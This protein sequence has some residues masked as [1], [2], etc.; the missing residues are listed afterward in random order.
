VFGY[1]LDYCNTLLYGM[2]QNTPIACKEY[3]TLSP[4]LYVMHHIVVHPSH[5]SNPCIGYQSSNVLSTNSPKRSTKFDYTSN[6]LT[7]SSTLVSINQ[8]VLRVHQIQSY[9]LFH[10]PKL[11]PQ[12]GLSASPS[13]L[14][15]I[16]CHPESEKHHHVFNCCAD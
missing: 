12:L 2:A 9:S 1:R 15:G 10:L 3:R 5:Y 8:F 4:D 16:V 11:Q 14:S 7:S 6:H 13:Q